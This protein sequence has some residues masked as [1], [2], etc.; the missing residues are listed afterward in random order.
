MNF[1][2]FLGTSR[3]D[4]QSQHVAKFVE[5]YISKQKN[6]KVELITSQDLQIDFSDEGQSA[7]S[8]EFSTKVEKADGY[9]LIVPEYNHSYPATIKYILDLNL[10]EYLHKPVL[11]VG[12]SSGAFGGARAIKSLLSV[13]RHIGLVAI[14]KDVNFS[15]VGDEIKDGQLVNPE[16]WEQRLSKAYD[17]FIWMAK[18]LKKAR[19]V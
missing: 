10:Q 11:M 6:I 4:N 7:N 18:A 8:D 12:V 16:K 19:S 1:L 3:Q 13:I 2:I 9:I 15:H 17:E 14:K 5:R